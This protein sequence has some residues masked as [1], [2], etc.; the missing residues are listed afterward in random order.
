MGYSGY[1]SKS[2][3][4]KQRRTPHEKARRARAFRMRLR[5]IEMGLRRR[6]EWHDANARTTQ[7]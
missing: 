4:R 2:D 3:K 7:D 6:R 5:R 1:K